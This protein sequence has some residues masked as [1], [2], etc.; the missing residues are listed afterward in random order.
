VGGLRRVSGNDHASFRLAYESLKRLLDLPDGVEVVDMEIE[1]DAR[2]LRVTIK[3]PEFRLLDN[4]EVV[5]PVYESFEDGTWEFS[6]FMVSDE[7][8]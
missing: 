3:S 2:T 8:E 5:K 1:R 4:N 7:E 6:G